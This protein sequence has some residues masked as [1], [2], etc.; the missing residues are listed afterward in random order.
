MVV[1]YAE[2]KVAL[3]KAFG[4]KKAQSAL[5]SREINKID[6]TD[7]DK[8]V[9]SAIISQVEENTQ[10]MPTTEELGRAMQDERPVPKH[11]AAATK[12]DEVYK[13]EDI[14][15]DEEWESIWVSDWVKS[16][17]VN[18]YSFSPFPPRRLEADWK[19]VNRRMSTSGP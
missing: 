11:N 19:V 18:T 16:V 15:S 12:A 13:R 4:T 10:D 7:M 17:T 5:T 3:G 1:Q 8:S 6:A 2:S 14:I 9:S